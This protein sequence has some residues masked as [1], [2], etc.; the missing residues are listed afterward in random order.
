M[1]GII[2]ISSS[3][4]FENKEVLTK[5]SKELYHRGPDDYGE[6]WM[7][8][9]CIGFAHRRLSI[10]D[11]SNKGHQ[12]MIDENTQNTIVFNGEIYNFKEIRS[13]LQHMGRK[14]ISNSDTEV[15]LKAYNEWGIDCISRFNGMFAF[16]IFDKKQQKI[17][18]AR[19]RSGEKPLYYYDDTVTFRF[20]SEL[21]GIL[22][23]PIVSRNLDFD[24]FDCYLKMGYAPGK[25]SMLKNFNKLPPGH[26][27]EFDLNKRISRIWR[28]WEPPQFEYNNNPINLE[29]TLESLLESSVRRQLVSDVP[30]GVLLS[31]GIDSSLIT[32][33]AS[34]EISKLKT[35][36]INFLGSGKFDE[37]KHAR[38]IANHFNTDHIELDAKPPS[39]DL[40]QKLANQFDEPIVDS[41]M[42]P[43]FLVSELVSQHCTVVLGGDGGDELFGGY[44]HHSRLL[45]IEKYSKL[46]P[47]NFLKLLAISAESYLSVGFKGRNWLQALGTDL[48]NDLPIMATYFDKTSRSKLLS[49]KLSNMSFVSEKIIKNRVPIE[50][51]LTQRV[52]R[53]DFNNF[54]PED[55]LTKLDRSS[56]LN[57]LEMRCPFLDYHILDFAFRKVPSSQKVTLKNK[58]ILLKSLARKILPTNF[59]YNRKQGFS[60]PMK[61]WLEKGIFRDFLNETLLDNSCIFNNKYI[62]SLLK[63]QDKG[64]N[65]SERLFS[66]LMFELWRQKFKVNL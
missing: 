11:R 15:I 34:K 46:L 22:A 1:C 58:K 13:T 24:S 57:S 63:N 38:L 5:G 54:L 42:I 2:G 7:E 30:I 3:K 21:K 19:D 55:V 52:T 51:D 60:A 26:V 49:R 20:A 35:F 40:L 59:D 33:F 23:D 14:F 41:S 65:N 18:L 47:K 56:M 64:Y 37:S 31:G 9:N 36:T 28:Y 6:V 43:T 45:F 27:L 44:E 29:S 8:N 39:I 12:P 66:L 16:S 25:M 50:K 32:A 17:F 62:L 53:M 4:P 10:I 48:E 61:I